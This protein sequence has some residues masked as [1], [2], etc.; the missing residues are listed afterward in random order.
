VDFRVYASVGDCMPITEP[1]DSTATLYTGYLNLYDRSSVLG[2]YDP[3]I[4][5]LRVHRGLLRMTLDPGRYELRLQAAGSTTYAFTV[6]DTLVYG[7]VF[8]RQCLS[9]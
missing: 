7:D 1:R 4:T 9:Y 2:Y 5:P 3:E 8:L 6:A